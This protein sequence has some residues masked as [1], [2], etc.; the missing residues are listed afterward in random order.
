MFVIHNLSA[1]IVEFVYK[2]MYDV[3]HESCDYQNEVK[4]NIDIDKI[5]FSKCKWFGKRGDSHGH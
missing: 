1:C 4:I 5:S 2:T 3:Y